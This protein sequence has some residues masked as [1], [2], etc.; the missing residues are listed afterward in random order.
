MKIALIHNPNAFRGEAEG[1]ELRRVFERAGHGVEYVN[2]R[3]PDWQRVISPEIARAIIVGGDGTVQLVAPHLKGTP[4]SV[5][6]FGTANNIAQCLHQ[7]A[8]P[9][10]LASQLDHAKIRHLDLGRVTHGNENKTFLEATGMGVFVELILAMQDWPKKLEMEQA[11]SRKEKFAKALEQLQMIC[12]EYQGMA[13]ELKVDDTVITDRFLLI[14]VMNMELIGP[15]L[16]LAP[17]ADPGDGYLDLV[18]V[19]ERDRTN[20]SRWLECQSPGETQA[21]N[22]ESRPCHRVAACASDVAPVHIDSD[23]VQRPEFPVIV[24]LEPAALKYAVLRG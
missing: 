13:W 7:T 19:R 10:L 22:L 16:H 18:F 6:P 20:L 17:N 3:E 14:A 9:N 1:S 12:R 21:A 11:E 5:L 8:D 4:F 15:R 23:L 24:E 2:I